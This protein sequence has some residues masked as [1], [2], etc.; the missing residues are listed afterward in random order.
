MDL[1]TRT[2]MLTAEAPHEPPPLRR[3]PGRP[4]LSNEQLLDKALDLFLEQGFERTSIEAIAAAAGMAKRTL[5]ARYPDKLSLFRA[6]LHRAIEEWILPIERLRAVESDDLEGTLLAIGRILVANIMTPSGL[7]L[8]RIT[9]A[10]SA[11]MPEIGQFTYREGTER[12]IGYLTEL[13]QRRIGQEAGQPTDWHEAAVAFL[14]L[15]TGPAT[16]TAWGMTLD[17]ETIDQ[18][19]VYCVRLFLH[20]LLPPG[21]S[22]AASGEAPELAGL[23]A[24]NRRLRDMLVASMLDVN[25]LK[26]RLAM[27]DAETARPNRWP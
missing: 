4:T 7:R 2:G 22:K 26:E 6:A 27:G 20:G 11:R 5:Y 13:F 19:T 8:L 10:E 16:V 15:V 12:T 18:H 14:Y 23:K 1:E 25:A 21:R 17:E 24:E 3:G 9:N